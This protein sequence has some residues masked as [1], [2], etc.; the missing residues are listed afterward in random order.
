MN[1]CENCDLPKATQEDF[2]TIP[3]GEGG[4]LCW[5]EWGTACEPAPWDERALEAA[6][7]LR[8]A[9][10]LLEN[11]REQLSE[12]SYQELKS[13]LGDSFSWEREPSEYVLLKLREQELAQEQ[14]EYDF[15]RGA[16]MMGLAAGL[17]Q[18]EEPDDV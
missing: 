18:G 2:D 14:A 5:D 4:H 3:G 7:V 1:R 16:Y 15:F 6:A 9:R 17:S 10:L 11:L 12:F 8:T 13:V